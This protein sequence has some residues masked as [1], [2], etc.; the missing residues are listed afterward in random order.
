MVDEHRQLVPPARRLRRPG[1]QRVRRRLV[2]PRRRR[3]R[4]GRHDPRPRSI[5]WRRRATRRSVPKVDLDSKEG[6]TAALASPNL[7]VRAMAMAKLRE[8]GLPKALEVLEAG[9]HAKGQSLPP[10]TRLSGSSATSATCAMST[11]P[12]GSRPGFP[13]PG[14]AHSHT[15]PR[16][17]RP[18]ITSP[19]GKHGS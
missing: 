8:Q 7:A 9:R 13:H 19:I 6:L 2:R 14:H 12:S 16:A 15:M 18:S 5:A 3:P 17:K 4:H 1:R 11:R 10:R